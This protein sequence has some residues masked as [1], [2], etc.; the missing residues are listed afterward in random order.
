M[1]APQQS[2]ASL[3]RGGCGFYGSPA[4]DSYC[5]VCY[6]KKI[7]EEQPPKEE[8]KPTEA[9]PVVKGA[10]PTREDSSVP[11]EDQPGREESVVGEDR[12][13]HETS[14]QVTQ[15]CRSRCYK[16]NK[17]LGLLGFTCRCGAVC[18]R[19]HLH[20]EEHNCPFDYRQLGRQTIQDRNPK[21][22]TAKL[23]QI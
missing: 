19:P 23:D 2:Q 20:A 6:R 3:C 8:A 21:V 10:L 13:P 14:S 1:Q 15:A 17:R 16:C 12:E 18:C 5:S 9:N 22:V 7:Q 4:T 11:Q